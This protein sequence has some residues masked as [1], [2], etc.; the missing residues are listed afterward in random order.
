VTRAG[1][2]PLV[3]AEGD[4]FAIG[5]EHGAAR[6]ASLRAFVDDS[7]CRLNRI[8]QPPVSL[9]ALR[10]TIAAYRAAIAAETPRLA[11]EVLGL[12]CGAGLG[13]DEAFLLQLRR[14]IMGYRKVVAAGDCTTYARAGAASGGN[15]VLAQTIDLNGD[16]DDQISVLEIAPAGSGRT[17]LVLSF[18]GLLGYLGVN[19]DGLA[20]GLNLVLGGEWRPGLPPYLAIRHL[21]DTAANVNEAIAILTRLRLASSRSISLC[22][23]VTAAY[24]EILGDEVRVHEAAETVHTNHFL[25]PDFAAA[26]E[27]NVFAR[28][29]SLRRLRAAETGL[30][31]LSP[32]ATAEDHFALLSSPPICVPDDGDI[33]RERT[34]AAAVVLPARGELHLRPGNPAHARTEVFAL[35]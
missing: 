20:V 30:A 15:P 6:A 28:N 25:H 7:L 27:I 23:P 1:R 9:D 13:E 32:A 22:D 2:I 24:V 19:S 33:R 26:D 4:A 29:S 35:H 34:V 11:E 3:R 21:L 16:L 17:A 18:A 12:A 5:R 8:V 31:G 14:E 10:P